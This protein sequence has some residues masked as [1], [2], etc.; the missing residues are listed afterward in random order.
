MSYTKLH[1]SILTSTVWLENNSTRIVWITL[2]ALADK[3]GEVESGIPGLASISRVT[4][5]ECI[6]AIET[7]LAPDK[8]S[9]TTDDDG[10]RIVEIEG[11]WQILNHEKYRLKA[12]Q[13]ERRKRDRD[14]QRRKRDRDAA[15]SVTQKAL[16][17]GQSHTRV[18]PEGYIAEA[19]E[20]SSKNLPG[21]VR[22]PGGDSNNERI[23]PIAAR[24]KG[25]SLPADRAHDTDK[26]LGKIIPKPKRISDL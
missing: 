5:P 16:Q 4:L 7:F 18:T 21:P 13:D 2:L 1:Q 6:A 3:N 25:G 10:R 24:A 15:N 17:N 23:L 20:D 8:F 19:E 12:S 26:E 11:G 14:R 9:R 22:S